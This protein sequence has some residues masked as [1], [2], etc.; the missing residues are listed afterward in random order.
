MFQSRYPALYKGA[1]DLTES[2]DAAYNRRLVPVGVSLSLFCIIVL[3]IALVHR[4]TQQGN[5]RPMYGTS[6]FPEVLAMA[7]HSR[8]SM[9]TFHPDFV[10]SEEENRRGLTILTTIAEVP[11]IKAGSSVPNK[12]ATGSLRASTSHF[13]SAPPPHSSNSVGGLFLALLLHGE[14]LS[15]F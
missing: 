13:P 2:D 1:V 14:R 11:L 7:G 6:T 10:L 9:Y 5:P 15:I 8:K 3:Y 4:M 12:C